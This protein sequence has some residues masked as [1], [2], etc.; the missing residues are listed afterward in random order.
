MKKLFWALSM[1]TTAFVFSQDMTNAKLQQ[2]ILKQSDSVMNK[3]VNFCE[4]VKLNRSIICVTDSIA[5]RMRIISPI[6]KIED[7]KSEHI[8]ASLAANFHTALDVKYAVSDGVI[9]SVF[10]HPLKELS[11]EQ[12]QSAIS[13]VYNANVTFGSTY[14]S[15]NLIFGGAKKNPASNKDFIENPGSYNL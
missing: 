2:L 10:I 4:I 14:Q 8:I 13:Q 7:L 3:S 9:W 5:N 6:A 12:V 1:L 11:S 15:T